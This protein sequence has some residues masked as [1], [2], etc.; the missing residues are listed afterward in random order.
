[1]D[2]IAQSPSGTGKTGAFCIG[3]LA[4]VDCSIPKVQVMILEPFRE[5]A[6][7]SAKTLTEIGAHMGAIVQCSIGGMSVGKDISAYR[8]GVHGVVGTPGRI[9][10]LLRRGNLSTDSLKVLVIDEADEM[11][12]SGFLEA[13]QDILREVPSDCQIAL[14]SAT[15]PPETLELSNRFMRDPIRI[16]LNRDEVNLKGI[17]QYYVDVGDERYKIDTLVDLFKSVSVSQCII[18]CNSRRKADTLTKLMSEREFPVV[19]IHSDL[20]HSERMEIMESFIRGSFRVLI[21]TDLIA[22]GIDVQGVEFV[23]N[24]DM[25]TDYENYVHR[26]GRGGRF[27]RKGV[28]INFVTA[29]DRPLLRQ[30]CEHYSIEIEPLPQDFVYSEF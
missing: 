14:F 27:G 15:L 4:R 22:R 1:L 17:K 9:L 3:S 19:C 21:A 2:I 12:S 5:L 7:Q 20:S 26:I 24:Y 8:K 11:L 29:R 30:L 13:M 25:T 18:F 10:D 6:V 28:A 23:L 16:V